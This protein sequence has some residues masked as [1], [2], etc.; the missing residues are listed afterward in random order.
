MAVQL[1]QFYLHLIVTLHTNYESL[2]KA[3]SCPNQQV[4]FHN[5][6]YWVKVVKFQSSEQK[7]NNL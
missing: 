2:P 4:S 3:V 7:T 5:K 1:S 6:N